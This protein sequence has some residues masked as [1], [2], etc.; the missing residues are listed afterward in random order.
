MADE[1]DMTADRDELEAPMRLAASRKPV[2]PPPTG[3]C[4]W[5]DEPVG[6]GMRYCDSEC[7]DD[8]E[9]MLR[10]NRRY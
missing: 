5:C 1:A 3:K 10:V 4:H 8:H 6:V 7:R 9:R 2:G